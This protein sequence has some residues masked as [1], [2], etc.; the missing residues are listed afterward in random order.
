MIYTGASIM[1]GRV[2]I[3]NTLETLKKLQFYRIFYLYNG[4]LPTTT[5][6]MSSLEWLLYKDYT[7]LTF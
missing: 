2:L 5:N 1:I 6:F 4:R 7:A 3:K